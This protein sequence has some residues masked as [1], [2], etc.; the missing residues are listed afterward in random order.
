MVA[1]K[2][3]SSTAG[4]EEAESVSGGDGRLLGF[5]FVCFKSVEDAQ[6]AKVEA[7]KRPFRGC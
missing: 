3:G 2:P 1:K 7:S 5:G 4:K 6:R